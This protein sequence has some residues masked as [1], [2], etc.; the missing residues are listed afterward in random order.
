MYHPALQFEM[1]VH[2]ASDV[3]V[4]AA[5]RYVLPATH[6]CTLT[7]PDVVP[8]DVL[9]LTPATHSTHVRSDVAV[10]ATV[11]PCPAKHTVVL[12]HTRSF[13]AVGATV[14]YW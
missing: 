4:P 13:H 3:A 8:A 2:T 6:V 7:H 14:W 12:P 9:K 1:D 5:D 10:P 11:T